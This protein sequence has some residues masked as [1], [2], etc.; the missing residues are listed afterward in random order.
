MGVV[1]FFVLERVAGEAAEG[2][3]GA[4]VIDAHVG[5]GVLLLEV[6]LAVLVVASSMVPLEG[7]WASGDPIGILAERACNGRWMGPGAVLS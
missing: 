5:A 1:P 6:V 2:T 3:K 4:A 7:T